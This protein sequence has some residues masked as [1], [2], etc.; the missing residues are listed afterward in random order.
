MST[1]EQHYRINDIVLHGSITVA[2]LIE[3][4]ETKRGYVKIPKGESRRVNFDTRCYAQMREDYPDGLIGHI[5][6]V[7]GEE[8]V[9]E[10]LEVVE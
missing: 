4:R 1:P 6:K 9:N 8:F 7:H 3:V 2:N 10:S 5:V